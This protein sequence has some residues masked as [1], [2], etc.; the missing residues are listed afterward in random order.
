MLAGT[1]NADSK[2]VVIVNFDCPHCQKFSGYIDFVKNKFEKKVVEEVVFAPIPLPGQKTVREEFYYVVNQYDPEMGL[3]ALKVLFDLAEKRIETSSLDVIVDWM[4]IE[5]PERVTEWEKF[6][7]ERILPFG[8]V[9]IKKAKY[10]AAKSGLMNLPAFIS[11][12]S[13]E[14][15]LILVDDS[16]NV[17]QKINGVNDYQCTRST[18]NES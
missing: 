13:E 12:S 17:A 10:L 3:Q 9:K 2:L 15:G 4:Q 14:V 5:N 8:S 1:A 7:D 18:R 16:S 11:V 6:R